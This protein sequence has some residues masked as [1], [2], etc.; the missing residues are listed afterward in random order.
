MGP[1]RFAKLVANNRSSPAEFVADRRGTRARH[2]P[3]HAG[4]SNT[5][6]A[7]TTT[8]A[9]YRA[10]V[11]ST[12]MFGFDTVVVAPRN[13]RRFG[14][15]RADVNVVVD[16]IQLLTTFGNQQK[17]KHCLVPPSAETSVRTATN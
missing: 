3:P 4:I 17:R 14:T 15:R 5:T 13:G 7:A 1:R 6:A 2:V 16:R 8:T 10:F 9:G 12:G 11:D